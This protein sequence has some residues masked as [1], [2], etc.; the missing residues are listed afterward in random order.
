MY[1]EL[2][3][4][5]VL[6]FLSFFKLFYSVCFKITN[7]SYVTVTD[8]KTATRHCTHKHTHT[9]FV[10]SLFIVCKGVLLFQK[11][12]QLEQGTDGVRIII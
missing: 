2:L 1:T 11:F 12:I 10:R 7:A 4:K 3:L 9:F 6:S 5:T 8:S